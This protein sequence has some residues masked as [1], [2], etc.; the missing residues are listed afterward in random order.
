MF[1]AEL[2]RQLCRYD[3]MAAAP[4]PNMRATAVVRLG[5]RLQRQ[6]IVVGIGVA[7]ADLHAHA[8]FHK[9]FDNRRPTVW[10][11]VWVHG[12][13]SQD[14]IISMGIQRRIQRL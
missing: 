5:R 14:T 6:G 10:A 9:F 7:N 12:G 8:L 3:V 13:G 11:K 4:F 2:G 1:A